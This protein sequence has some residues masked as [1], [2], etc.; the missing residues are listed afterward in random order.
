MKARLSSLLPL[1]V[2]CLAVGL[3]GSAVAQTGGQAEPSSPTISTAGDGVVRRAPDR[4]F[5]DVA[6]ETRAKDPREAQ[7]RNAETMTGVQQKL[8]AT[9]LPKDALR[10]VGYSVAPEFDFV[11][12]RRVL[13]G[14]VA[15]N[16]IEVRLDDLNRVGEILDLAAASGATS[17]G[18]VRFD[19]KDRQA[20]E[21]E[22]LALAVAGA[23]ARAEAIAAAAGRS[24]VTIWRIVDEGSSA[25]GPRPVF[26]AAVA[27]VAGA[28]QT[29]ISA[30]DIEVRAHVTLIVVIK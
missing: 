9:K 22:A 20:A 15:R 25:P 24:I 10:T 23:K 29:P 2:A 4:A 8:L 3:P 26:R 7:A 30:G 6:V 28:P 16:S 21:R 5:I 19:L 12:G 13:R 18:D 11:S 17:V 14:Y 27:E 1:A